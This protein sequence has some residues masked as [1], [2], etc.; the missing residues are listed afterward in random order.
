MFF[1]FVVPFR[2]SSRF[3]A[4]SL[5]IL[6]RG[7]A[8]KM[9]QHVDEN[10]PV[11]AW[12]FFFLFSFFVS[13]SFFSRL[14][15]V[16]FFLGRMNVSLGGPRNG[17]LHQQQQ[18]QQ[19]HHLSLSLTLSLSSTCFARFPL[20]NKLTALLSNNTNSCSFLPEETSNQTEEEGE[21]T[22]TTTTTTRS[23]S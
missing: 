5:R 10:A 16:L 19:R 21:T 13:L 15:C 8:V 12:L 6:T 22:T 11:R 4:L 7:K 1:I 18:Q 23:Q 20:S 17:I 9:Q 2:N 14:C 3:C